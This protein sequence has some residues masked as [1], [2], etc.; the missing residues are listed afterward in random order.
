MF[1]LPPVAP[2]L[3]V[4]GR[5]R[6][7]RDYYLR[8]ASNDYSTHPSAIGSFVDVSYDL[9]EVRFATLGRGVG[10]HRRSW[11][12]AQTITDPLHVEAAKELRHAFQAPRA[13]SHDD[14]HRDLAD[15]D[16]F[17]QVAL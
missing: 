17:F 6:L 14:W 7:A 13:Q 4:L 11:A 1:A 16:E 3:G 9:D 10:A 12:R 5:V 2:V 15:Y 8:V